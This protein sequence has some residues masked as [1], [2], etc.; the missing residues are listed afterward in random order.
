MPYE[1]EFASYGPLRRIVESERV[2]TL[3]GRA[4]VYKPDEAADSSDGSKPSE[5][6]EWDANLPRFVVAIDG[7]YT[8]VPVKTGYPGAKVGYVTVAS[9]LMDLSLIE[10]LDSDRPVD[11]VQYRKTESAS[12]IDAA[13]PGSNVVTRRQK[14]ARSSFRE[15][16]FDYFN[17]IIIDEEDGIPLIETYEALLDLK[18]TTQK[19]KCPYQFDE[20]D[21]NYEFSRLPKG[22]SKCP[23]CGGVVFSTDALR[24]H[25]RFRDLGTNGEAFGLVM[26][27]WERIL[28]VHL[29][30]CFEARQLL[31]KIGNLAFFLDGPLA[32]FG[33]PAWLSATIS[34]EL[35]RINAEVKKGT[36]KDLLILG[37][38][39]SGEFVSHFEEIDETEIPGKLLFQ[40]RQHLLLTDTYIKRRIQ[41]SNSTKRYG[42]DTY[43]GRK[44]FYKTENGAHIV[45]NIPFLTD[46]QDSL[47]SSDVT[48]YPRFGDACRLLD[49]LISVR[50]PN[51]LAPLISAHAEASIPLNLGAKVLKQLAQALMAGRL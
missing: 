26:Q 39:K 25:E 24:I 43:F 41:Q 14:A 28:L 18:P 27:I 22:H 7:S 23:S 12:A 35:K 6:P 8:E 13:L 16:L 46:E 11:P 3:L 40:P 44:F 36:H 29:L 21:C 10:L 34:A 19:Q 42:L 30:R 48:I 33:P 4:N 32:V 45:G 38:E 37:I 9:V 51:S 49:K 31:D 20:L 47:T 50:Y 15:E 17:S 1:N 5:T 2:Q